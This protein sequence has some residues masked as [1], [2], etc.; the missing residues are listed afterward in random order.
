VM[1]ARKRNSGERGGAVIEF[2]LLI[3]VLLLFFLGVVDF[4][5]AISQ[6]MALNAAAQAGA[7]YGASEGY[8]YNTA[9]MATAA[10][11]AAP[12]MSGMTVT[13]SN[14]CT[15]TAGGTLVNCATT[16][17][18]TYD[19]PMQYAQVQTSAAVPLLFHFA[20]IPLNIQ[21]SATAVM[22]VR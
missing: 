16:M 1:P 17:C 10:T 4:S 15:C 18:N 5:L 20:G 14:Y 11:T 9:A 21:M 13:A 6:S 19:L 3:T 7:R 2:A 22:R 8:F 12:S